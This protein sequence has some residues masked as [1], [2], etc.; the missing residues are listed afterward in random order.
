[1]EE[2]SK[3]NLEDGKYISYK[4]IKNNSSKDYLFFY[5]HGYS[6]NMDEAKS[7]KIEEIAK[8]IILI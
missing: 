8:K 5:I 6:D 1:M 4:F 3:L 2:K 7:M